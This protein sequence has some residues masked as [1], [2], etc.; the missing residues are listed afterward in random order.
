M[1]SYLSLFFGFTKFYSIR[2]LN[3]RAD[4]HISKLGLTAAEEIEKQLATDHK[5]RHINI[6]GFSMGGIVARAM[7]PHLAEH[8]DKFNLLVT[9]ASPHLG[10]SEIESC[11]V[12]AGL[13]YMR[14]VS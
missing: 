3:L 2:N 5:I 9:L 11:L 13:Y 1:K 10:I 6:V 8:R 12:R 7:L 4:E 14:E